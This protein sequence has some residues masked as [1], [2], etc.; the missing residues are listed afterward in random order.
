MQA[1]AQNLEF[2]QALQY[3]NKIELLSKLAQRT[4]QINPTK[5]N[6]QQ[7]IVTINHPA[8]KQAKLL[9]FLLI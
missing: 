9:I 5:V 3:K 6:T 2:E 4:S 7:L 8:N 1:H